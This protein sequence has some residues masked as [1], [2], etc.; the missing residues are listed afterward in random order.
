MVS[1]RGITLSYKFNSFTTLVELC[2]RVRTFWSF[3]KREKNHK[4]SAVLSLSSKGAHLVIGSI[5]LFSFPNF[6]FFHQGNHD[7]L[8]IN[9]TVQNTM[10][11]VDLLYQWFYM[12]N[13]RVFK[14]R[15]PLFRSSLFFPP[16]SL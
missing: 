10:L 6:Q 13:P 15:Q 14:P 9:L 16:F 11:V 2:G 7:R 12:I 5:E 8:S 3:T 1:K 4:I